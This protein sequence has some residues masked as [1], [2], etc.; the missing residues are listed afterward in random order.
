MKSTELKPDERE[1]LKRA[2]D[3]AKDHAKR[4]GPR[5]VYPGEELNTAVLHMLDPT[6]GYVV[7]N[8]EWV[9]LGGSLLCDAGF[10]R[11]QIRAFFKDRK[12]SHN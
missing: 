9:S 1:G 3:N 2:M 8:I 7:G 5:G 12:E 10:S 4:G 6:R 11:D